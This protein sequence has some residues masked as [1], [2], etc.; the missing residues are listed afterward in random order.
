MIWQYELTGGIVESGMFSTMDVAINDLVRRNE[1]AGREVEIVSRDKELVQFV[2]VYPTAGRR[3]E[4]TLSKLKQN[5][6][7]TPID[8]DDFIE[9]MAELQKQGVRRKEVCRKLGISISAFIKINKLLRVR[10]L[11]EKNGQV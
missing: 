4:G 5:T 9:P 2:L 3:I 7:P 6:G 11:E 8:I 1:A 10:K